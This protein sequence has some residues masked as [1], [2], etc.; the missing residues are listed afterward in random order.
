MKKN[1]WRNRLFESLSFPTLLL[2]PQMVVTAANDKF[3][4]KYGY[5]EEDLIGKQ[6]NQ[7]LCKT[8]EPCPKSTCP[9]Y[10]VLNEKRGASEI[11][12][13]PG[14]DGQEVYED[15]VCSPIFN[16]KG[17]VSYIMLSLRDVT[18]T[19]L[20]ELELRK[21]NDFLEN[22]IASSVSAIVVADMKGVVLLM[23][24]SARRLFGYT[25]QMAVGKS[26]AE[27]LYTPGGA[28]SVMKKLRS[29]DYGGVGKLHTTEMT[30]IHSSGDE[31]PVEMNASII[32]QDAREIATMGIYTDLRP[33]IAIERKLKEAE[34]IKM[35]QSNKMASLGHL[36]A[37]VAHEINNPLSGILI[38]TN[39][40]LEELEEGSPLCK[41]IQDIISDTNRC[42]DIVKNLLAY[43]R[44]TEF[45]KEVLNIN[46]VIEQAFS[47]M[48]E[49]ALLQNITVHKDFSS[50]MLI[51]EGDNNQ[52][53][54]VFTNMIINATQAMN[55]KGS[56]TIGASKD[57]AE[58]KIYVEISDTGCG[59]PQENIPKIFEPFFTTKEEGKGTGLGL[60]TVRDILEKHGGNIKVKY[61]CPEGT[62]FLIEL[63]LI[64]VDESTLI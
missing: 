28:R 22:I 12:E 23:N 27:Y 47:F 31:I 14:S 10:H 15:R 42:K 51:C 63:P 26:I 58:G 35:M 36:A 49:H 18:R 17:D 40:I 6:C 64:K 4:D 25:D 2:T 57:K 21:T 59:I 19:K 7:I 30:V 16:E 39:L 37:G 60:S 11:I 56:I 8:D 5:R 34:R 13:I 20:L 43:S 48:R 62:T 29:P 54:Q 38:D 55:G 9:I 41:P 1:N 32:Y 53:L 45:K 33:R 44:Q 24:E 3:L 50:S 61:T 52:L 46:G